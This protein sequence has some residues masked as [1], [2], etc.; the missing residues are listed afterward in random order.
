MDKDK[1]SDQTILF[2]EEQKFRQWWLWMI[3][4]MVVV[5]IWVAFISHVFLGKSFDNN[6]PPDSIIYMFFVLF[7]IV[8]PVF[9]YVLA[10]RVRITPQGIQ[11]R[12]YPVHVKW[13]VI[14]MDDIVSFQNVIYRPILEYGGWGIRYGFKGK[15]YNVSG[16]KGIRITKRDGKRILFGSQ[17][18]G[19]F[20]R[21]LNELG[22]QE[23]DN[24]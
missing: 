20:A 10:L 2:S 21:A 15:A 23:S 1:T 12:F 22:L 17:R 5:F 11:F 14:S 4:I 7:G 3:V 18:P 9:F 8:F 24:K 13:Y 6:P 16:N 19:E